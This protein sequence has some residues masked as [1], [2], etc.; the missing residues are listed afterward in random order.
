MGAALLGGPRTEGALDDP[1]TMGD[2]A[3]VVVLVGIEAAERSPPFAG[4]A[5]ALGTAAARPV[6]AARVG[7]ATGRSS[8]GAMST[9]VALMTT[10]L[11]GVDWHMRNRRRRS[12]LASIAG[13]SG[14]S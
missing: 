6:P 9:L 8:G 1:F 12:S 11:A 2:P 13:A 7:P 14:G 5:P 3:G 10:S 4:R